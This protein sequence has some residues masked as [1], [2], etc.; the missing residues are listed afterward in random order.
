M[1]VIEFEFEKLNFR[2]LGI[3]EE[4]RIKGMLWIE[5]LY[6]KGKS[7]RMICEKIREFRV[8][9]CKVYGKRKKR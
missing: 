4:F 8:K 7:F 1:K 6:F 2:L 3:D 9:K 5:S